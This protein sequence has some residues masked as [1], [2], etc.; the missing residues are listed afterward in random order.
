MA[1]NV[2]V[3]AVGP[4]GA[5]DLPSIVEKTFSKA[6]SAH[7]AKV[8]ID[9]P[10]PRARP[11]H[12][13]VVDEPGRRSATITATRLV[14]AADEGTGAPTEL[15]A[16]VSRRRASVVLSGVS[17][18]FRLDE[19]RGAPGLAVFEVDGIAPERARVTVESLVAPSMANA[20]DGGELSRARRSLAYRLGA[21][22]DAVG[23]LADVLAG[24]A[25]VDAPSS[26]L[27]S[28]SVEAAMV[29]PE[30]IASASSRILGSNA[31]WCWWVTHRSSPRP[32]AR[33]AMSTWS[34]PPASS[35]A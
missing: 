25:A 19:L 16:E 35:S 14:P 11:L 5:V 3:V 17:I 13:I 28:Q 6:P 18:G 29:S 20:P 1:E 10:A 4:V 32:S 24:F 31:W 33:W 12:L 30:A 27:E 23:G 8:D 21:E 34:T 15:F 9:E 26:R 7:A 22:I 2:V